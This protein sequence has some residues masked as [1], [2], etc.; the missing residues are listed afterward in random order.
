[1]KSTL[2]H[3]H[4]IQGDRLILRHIHIEKYATYDKSEL[5]KY[6]RDKRYKFLKAKLNFLQIIIVHQ[7]KKSPPCETIP[8]KHVTTI[9]R[10]Y[11]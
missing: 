7:K 8:S 10:Y 3:I 5:H 4:C 9:K 1:M 6:C 11:C 2:F